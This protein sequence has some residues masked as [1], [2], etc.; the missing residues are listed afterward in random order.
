MHVQ[1]GGILRGYT[2]ILRFNGRKYPTNPS[3]APRLTARLADTGVKISLEDQRN[4]LY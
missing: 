1:G 2:A 3:L 4:L